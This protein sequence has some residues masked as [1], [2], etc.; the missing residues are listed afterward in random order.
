MSHRYQLALSVFAT[1]QY[2]SDRGCRVA[3]TII[4]IYLLA[5]TSLFSVILSIYLRTFVGRFSLL[6]WPGNPLPPIYQT[7]FGWMVG[8]HNIFSSA[9]C[10]VTNMSPPLQSIPHCEDILLALAY[11][12]K[13]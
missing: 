10:S 7:V 8:V 13:Q 5:S 9:L 11:E 12:I 2:L 4:L 6:Q 1:S 3:C